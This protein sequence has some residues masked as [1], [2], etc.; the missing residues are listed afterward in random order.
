MNQKHLTDDRLIEMC[1]AGTGTQ[2][3]DPH[4]ASCPECEGRRVTLTQMLCDLSDA[5]A[6][7]ADAAFPEDWLARQ[8]AR[9]LQRIDIEGRPGRVIAFP[10]SHPQEPAVLRRR[11]ASRWVAGAAAAGLVIG[12]LAGHLAHDLPGATR[13]VPPQVVANDSPAPLGLRAVSTTMSDDEFLGQVEI[14]IGSNGP[15]AL[16]PLD[17]LT[18]RAWDVAAQ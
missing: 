12:L 2:A 8:R 1:V 3:T 14:A 9:I 11:P 13:V 10:A 5:A 6:A 15:A 18:P 4:L 16:R 7:D 17:V